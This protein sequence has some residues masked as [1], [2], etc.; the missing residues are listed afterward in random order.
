MKIPVSFIGT[1]MLFLSVMANSQLYGKGFVSIRDNRFVIKKEPYHYLGVNLW[2]GMNLGRADQP[3]ARQRLVRE[4]D[5][6]AALGVKNLRVMAAS[7]G[8]DH[9]PIRVKPSLQPAPGAYNQHV[10]LGLDF[11]LAEMAKRNMKAVL[12]LANYW[13]WSGGLGQYLVW[14]GDA[15]QIPY[16]PPLDGD[17]DSYQR[18]VAR[19][20]NNETAKSL[21][22]DHVE[23]IVTRTNSITGLAYRDDP[24]IMAWELCSEPRA[25]QHPEAFADWVATTSSLIHRLDPNHLITLGSEG[26]T[27]HPSYSNTDYFEDHNFEH[28][29]YGTMHIWPENFGWYDPTRPEKTFQQAWQRTLSYIETHI[30]KSRKLG[31]PLVLEEFGLARDQR[32]FSS[33]SSTYWRDRYYRLVLDRV[34]QAA[35]AGQPLIGANFWSW[36]GEGR[37]A[38]PG[39]FWQPGDD[40]LGDP[41]H[42]KQGWYGVYH[43]DDSTLQIIQDYAEKFESIR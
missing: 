13:E 40:L 15:A 23:H 28:I 33:Q 9:E 14:A 5:R 35:R 42:E 17:F 26:D 41:A 2:Y 30:T 32:D 16:P 43:T 24:T 18:F 10:L 27:P 29:D 1:L 25:M 37:P 22:T 31:K 36:S 21:Y 38:T 34:Y 6:L 20:Y 4:L 19:F 8:P 7:E 11:L 3:E 39:S 12:V